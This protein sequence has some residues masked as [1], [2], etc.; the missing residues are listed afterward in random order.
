MGMF[1]FLSNIS[2]PSKDKGS[3]KAEE[4]SNPIKPE[5]K[6]SK[7]ST[8]TKPKRKSS[9]KASSSDEPV[10][11]P[12]IRTAQALVDQWNDPN[13]S[14]EE[15]VELWTCASEKRMVLEDGFAFTPRQSAQTIIACRNAF[16]D[17]KFTYESITE[18]VPGKV[19]IEGFQS[20]GT[21]T[22]APYSL[23]PGFAPIAATQKHCSNDPERFCMDLDEDHKISRNFVIALGSYSGL[24]GFYEQI[25]GSMVPSESEEAEEP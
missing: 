20:S 19:V 6:S 3:A 18:K 11:S 10:V 9:K 14:E 25:G 13:F 16:P 1:S 5:K 21:H 2:K 17:L 22:G 4:T 15:F 7:K 24:A 12:N 8:S 23:G